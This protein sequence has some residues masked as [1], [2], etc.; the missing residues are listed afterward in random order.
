MLQAS[1]S[2]VEDTSWDVYP[3]YSLSIGNQTMTESEIANAILRTASD[4][5]INGTAVYVD[6]QLLY[7]T[8]EGDHLRSYLENIKAPFENA[9]DSSVYTAF[10]HNIRLV[11]GVYLQE[12]VSSYADVINAL[13]E[14]GGIHTYTAVDGDTVESVVNAT[15]VSFDSL[16]QMN[17]NC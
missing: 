9:M 7:V 12:S 8:T 15:G 13:T 11:D 17:P 5:I 16:A 6:D 14:G 1:G 10:A 3:T 2:A 4:E